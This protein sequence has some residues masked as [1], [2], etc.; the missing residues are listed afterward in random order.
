MPLTPSRTIPGSPVAGAEPEGSLDDYG[1]CGRYLRWTERSRRQREESAKGAGQERCLLSTELYV[2]VRDDGKRISTGNV[3]GH[4][5][6]EADARRQ[7]SRKAVR[8]LERGAQ[9]ASATRCR[10]QAVFWL[11]IAPVSIIVNRHI[12]WAAS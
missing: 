10:A 2:I 4:R 3:D 5:A 12:E 9:G 7:D 11:G 8:F 6:R 1:R